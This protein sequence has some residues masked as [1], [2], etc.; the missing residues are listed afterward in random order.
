MSFSFL[1][2]LTL[3]SCSPC[4]L[5]F[6]ANHE[7]NEKQK[8]KKLFPHNGVRS[9][10]AYLESLRFQVSSLFLIFRDRIRCMEKSICSQ[11]DKKKKLSLVVSNSPRSHKVHGKEHTQP[12]KAKIRD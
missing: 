8:T 5:S 4:L 3:L 2:S 1:F 7:K 6:P 11:K 12:R 10:L 9:W